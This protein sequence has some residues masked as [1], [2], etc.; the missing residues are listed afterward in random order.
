M[1]LNG[2]GRKPHREGGGFGQRPRRRWRAGE[3]S[4]SKTFQA[5]TEDKVGVSL[6]WGEQGA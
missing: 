2:V 5:R 1:T 3:H 6:L 4:W